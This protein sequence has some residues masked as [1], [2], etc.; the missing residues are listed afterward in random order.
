MDVFCCDKEIATA[1]QKMVSD[2][3]NSPNIGDEKGKNYEKDSIS[4]SICL[5]V[6][7]GGLLLAVP[8]ESM[9]EGSLHAAVLPEGP[10]PECMPQSMPEGTVPKSMSE[11][12]V[13]SDSVPEGKLIEAVV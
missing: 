10:V 11:G 13:P 1:P 8:A 9:P 6:V 12:P 4:C 3:P 7:L 2:I 5:V